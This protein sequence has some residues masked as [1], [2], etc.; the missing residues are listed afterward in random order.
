MAA[1]RIFLFF[2]RGILAATRAA[3]LMDKW[4]AAPRAMVAQS[5]S[6]GAMAIAAM[7]TD[8]GPHG[9]GISGRHGL[10]RP[11]Q[12]CALPVCVSSP[13]SSA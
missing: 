5:S 2:A 9:G 3:A 7:L 6:A 10:N 11:E 13:P 1:E 4:R 8:S 12:P